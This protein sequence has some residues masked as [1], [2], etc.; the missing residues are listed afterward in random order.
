[1]R[2]ADWHSAKVR[3]KAKGRQSQSQSDARQFAMRGGRKVKRPS[4]QARLQAVR[5]D[6][7]L[8][9][10]ADFRQADVRQARRA[11]VKHG[12]EGVSRAV[13]RFA[14][15]E[16][17]K[18]RPRNTQHSPKSQTEQLSLRS[19]VARFKRTGELPAVSV[20]VVRSLDSNGVDGKALR[21]MIQAML[22]RAGIEEDP[23][24]TITVENCP[25]QGREIVGEAV[26]VGTKTVYMCPLCPMRLAQISAGRNYHPQFQSTG[27]QPS[28][29]KAAQPKLSIVRPADKGKQP[30]AAPAPVVSQAPP[31]QAAPGHESPSPETQPQSQTVD[32]HSPPQQQSQVAGQA[33]QQQPQAAGQT[34]LHEQQPQ[35][36]DEP[37]PLSGRELTAADREAVMTAA[38]GEYIW[39]SWRGGHCNGRPYV[40]DEEITHRRM[41]LPYTGERRLIT[42]RNVQE[43]KAGMVVCEM[44]VDRL[45]GDKLAKQ[46]AA[47]SLAVCCCACLLSIY[48]YQ[49]LALALVSAGAAAWFFNKRLAQRSF[50]VSYVPHIVSCLMAEYDRGTSATVVRS[51]IGMRARRLGAL[52]IPD[53]YHEKLVADSVFVASVLLESQTFFG[54]GVACFAP[55]Q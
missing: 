6:V 34:K 49:Y 11:R 40:A 50:F 5:R 51:T 16:G 20:A 18:G 8:P 26:K 53:E 33:K 14:L 17:L 29:S 55:P 3:N 31:P 1:M 13:R 52:P 38:V 41:V 24:P 21:R 28:T 32:P 54:A 15:E 47:V 42:S 25:N 7:D 35:A 9:S 36:E 45:I 43:V 48:H 44:H 30:A 12:M 2:A 10:A 27:P 46:K 23:G 39:R 19:L 37:K 22:I 4:R